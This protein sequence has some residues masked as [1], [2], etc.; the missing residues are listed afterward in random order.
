[1]R[2]Y[3]GPYCE[4]SPLHAAALDRL[5][6]VFKRLGYGPIPDIRLVTALWQRTGRSGYESIH[7]LSREDLVLVDAHAGWEVFVD[8]LIHEAAHA[9]AYRTAPL[10]ESEHSSLWGTLYAKLYDTFGKPGGPSTT[11][12]KTEV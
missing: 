2:F 12:R 4:P 10:E 6:W 8:T 7:G 1:M 9:L 3:R 11:L 5:E